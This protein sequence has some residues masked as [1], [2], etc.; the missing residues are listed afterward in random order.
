MVTLFFA[1]SD[2]LPSFDFELDLCTAS[3]YIDLGYCFWNGVSFERGT[4][5]FLGGAVEAIY[6]SFVGMLKQGL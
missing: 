4:G 6:F 5:S 2:R 3:P 1:E